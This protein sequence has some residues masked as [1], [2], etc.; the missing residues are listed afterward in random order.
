MVK[1]ASKKAGEKP[2]RNDEIRLR[3]VPDSFFKELQAIAPLVKETTIPGIVKK[4]ISNYRM[5]Q[6]LIKQVQKRNDQLHEALEAFQANES[7][8]IGLIKGF[9]SNTAKFNSMTIGV[10]EGL[11]RGYEIKKKAAS[12]KVAA[13]RKKGGKK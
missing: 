5:D 10:A 6:D 11:L 7:A 4:L 1:K 13:R 8:T 3:N 2:T 9:I 12:K